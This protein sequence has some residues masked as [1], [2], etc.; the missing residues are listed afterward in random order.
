MSILESIDR[1]LTEWGQN[2]R[3]G[4]ASTSHGMQPRD[5]LRHVLAALEDNRVEG[6]DHNIYAP[7]VFLVSLN[8]EEE[9]RSRLLPFITHE[10]LEAAI[11]RYCQE[12]KYQFRGALQVQLREGFSPQNVFQS[13]P[14]NPDSATE[15][16][17]NAARDPYA[18]KIEVQ[19]RYFITDNVP[20]AGDQFNTS[21]RTYVPQ[22]SSGVHIIGR[23][24]PRRR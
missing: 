17:H 10:E 19:T 21:D 7:N 12:R 4:A 9:E 20:E 6:L 22:E 1:T 23:D 2:L 11:Q 18:N 16:S 13:I 5:V 24:E 15:Q 14:A 8:L 3:G